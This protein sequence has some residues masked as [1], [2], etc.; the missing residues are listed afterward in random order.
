MSKFLLAVNDVLLFQLQDLCMAP[1]S[2]IT[3]AGLNNNIYLA[4]ISPESFKL[5]STN[6]HFETEDF[7]IRIPKRIL[8]PLIMEPCA[9]YFETSQRIT[10][11]KVRNE[12][13]T[14]KVTFCL[15]LDLNDQ[16]I[17][18]VIS[19]S[20]QASQTYDMTPLADL[21]PLVPFSQSGI[22]FVD[23]LAYIHSPGFMAFRKLEHP[24]NFILTQ[25]TIAE[26]VKFTKAYGNICL[27]E[28]GNYLVFRHDGCFFGCRQPAAFID[29]NYSNY[30]AANPLM[31][32]ECSFT[33][34]CQLLKSFSIPKHED[35]LATF[36]FN[37]NVIDISPELDCKYVLRLEAK[38]QLQGSIKLS[39][40][41]LK[42]VF[43]NSM[44]D[45][46]AV[47][48]VVYQH[49]V[50]FRFGSIHILMHRYDEE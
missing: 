14:A 37:N 30:L 26:L 16:F 6:Q 8:H 29:S 10:V 36:D 40:D 5:Y 20:S 47:E 4:S 46:K 42:Q 15:E 48:L 25:K 34:L 12:K 22:Q 45:Y 2:H 1:G 19:N 27:F 31:Q 7:S 9:L 18:E 3:I 24:I 21:K 50:A 39:V 11:S 23:N 41:V 33:E 43:S 32:T 17:S 44:L 38:T 35:P 28:S 13:L 49:F